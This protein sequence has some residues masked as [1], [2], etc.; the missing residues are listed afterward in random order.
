MK[1]G[2]AEGVW[3]ETNVMTCAKESHTQH[4]H[5]KKRRLAM[6]SRLLLSAS[7]A[8]DDRGTRVHSDRE[9]GGSCREGDDR[10]AI[11]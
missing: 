4:R 1:L 9:K 7:S 11:P 5:Y 3:K 8:H 2:E 10:L 6:E